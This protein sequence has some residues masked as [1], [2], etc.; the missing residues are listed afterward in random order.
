MDNNI[1]FGDAKNKEKKA[2][3]KKYFFMF[4]LSSVDRA[5]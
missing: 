1:K 5:S 2:T 4:F 3:K